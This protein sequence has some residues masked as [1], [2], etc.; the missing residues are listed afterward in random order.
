[1]RL[2]FTCGEFS[3][4]QAPVLFISGGSDELVPSSMMTELFN[5]C[6][7]EDKRLARFPEGTH[8]TTWMCPLY[9]QTVIYFLEEVNTIT[10]QGGPKVNQHSLPLQGR[11]GPPLSHPRPPPPSAFRAG[12]FAPAADSSR[13]SN[14]NLIEFVIKSLKEPEITFSAINHHQLLLKNILNLIKDEAI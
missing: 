6:G 14:A 1:M 8:D 11:Q 4:T 9:N 3:T 12:P 10:L 7:A 2:I 5:A 13:R